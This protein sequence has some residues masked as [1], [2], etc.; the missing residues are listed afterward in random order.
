M[1]ANAFQTINAHSA[2]QAYQ[3]NA[4]RSSTFSA[5]S[6]T[7]SLSA[8]TSTLAAGARG[9]TAEISALARELS[10]HIREV[11]LLT[12]VTLGASGRKYKTLDEVASDFEDSL[13]DFKKLFGEFFGALNLDPSKALT[14]QLDGK[15]KVVASGENPQTEAVNRT[16]SQNDVLVSR[17]AVMAARA[18]IVN[19]ADT[20]P[21]FREA[22]ETNPPGAIKEY[23]GEL[24]DRLLG[25]QMNVSGG[26]FG[27][28]FD[29]A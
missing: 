6:M 14:L 13:T 27:W 29:H 24:K 21:G 2:S 5:F 7:A 1:V 3:A 10:I 11:T 9:D 19:A 8:S 22:Y 20:A 16:F 23:I 25:F 17:F 15:G 28:G 12:T 4:A 26:N 18:A